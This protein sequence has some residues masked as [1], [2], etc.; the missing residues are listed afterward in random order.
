MGEG[1]VTH[2]VN[3][4]YHIVHFQVDP[5]L[6][7]AADVCTNL[8]QAIT[9]V[10]VCANLHVYAKDSGTLAVGLI[11]RWWT[12]FTGHMCPSALGEMYTGRPAGWS[13][14]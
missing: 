4:M 3:H 8:V 11:W 10:G 13:L 1:T 9:V 5:L 2:S 6:L 7:L 14:L 12:L